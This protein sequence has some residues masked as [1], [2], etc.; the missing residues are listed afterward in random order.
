MAVDGRAV[1]EYFASLQKH[2]VPLSEE[3]CAALAHSALALDV[4]AWLAQ[5]LCRI[6]PKRKQFITWA[7]LKDQ[8]G[9]GY[10]RMIDFKRAFREIL[11]AVRTQYRG[12][13]FDVDD[14]GMTLFYSLPPSPAGT[15][16]SSRTTEPPSSQMPG[17]SSVFHDHLVTGRTITWSP[18][19]AEIRH[20]RTITWSHK[21]IYTVSFLPVVGDQQ[22]A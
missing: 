10:R 7:A 1:A 3:A 11:A 17:I 9:F 22:H 19:L 14:H 2:A 21:P 16:T 4:Y 8:F 5:R 12:A 15:S 20:F 13:K 6:R 18:H